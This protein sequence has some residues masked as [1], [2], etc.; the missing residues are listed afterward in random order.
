MKVKRSILCLCMIT[1]SLLFWGTLYSAQAANEKWQ[2]YRNPEFNIE[3]LTMRVPMEKRLDSPGA[4]NVIWH[5]GYMEDGTNGGVDAKRLKDGSLRFFSVTEQ[6]ANIRQGMDQ[7]RKSTVVSQKNILVNGVPAV[8]FRT[9][10]ITSKGT[11]W[12]GVA[13]VMVIEDT[14]YTIM[15][16]CPN[17]KGTRQPNIIKFLDSLKISSK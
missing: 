9:T 3:F 16:A 10:S 11:L 4:V 7:S 12:Y 5:I 1:L 6:A 17:E 8:E 13:R 15:I 14:F 2:K